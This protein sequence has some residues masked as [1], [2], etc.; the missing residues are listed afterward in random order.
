MKHTNVR[1]LDDNLLFIISQRSVAALV[2]ERPFRK[3]NCQVGSKLFSSAKFE[4]RAVKIDVNSF[5]NG[6]SS[7]MDL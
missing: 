6:F 5:R 2:V 1:F 4:I 3:P 7:A